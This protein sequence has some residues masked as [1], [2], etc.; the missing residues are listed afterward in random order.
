M[1]ALK[2]YYYLGTQADR[3]SVL[4]THKLVTCYDKLGRPISYKAMVFLPYGTRGKW[5]VVWVSYRR[6]VARARFDRLVKQ[7]LHN[8]TIAESYDFD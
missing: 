5:S 1:Q 6:E 4:E 2:D 7:V 3:E 8:R